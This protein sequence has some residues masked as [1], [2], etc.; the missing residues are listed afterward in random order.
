MIRIPVHVYKKFLRFALENANPLDDSQEWRECIGLIL[1]QIDIDQEEITVSDIVPIDTGSSV[2]VDITSYEKVFS[3][4]PISRIEQGEVI[5]GWAHTHP[6]LGLF[7]SGTDKRTQRLYQQMH[8]MSFG[9]VL[10]PM[11]VT[12]D[13]AGFKIFRVDDTGSRAFSV[14]YLLEEHIDFLNARDHIISDLYP[15]PVDLPIQHSITEVS[16]RM[17]KISIWGPEEINLN[18]LLE[19]KLTINLPE[20]QFVRAEYEIQTDRVVGEHVT[21]KFVYD[22]PFFHEIISSGV[23]SIHSFRPERIGKIQIR[24]KNLN[25][26]IYQQ[27]KQEMP[28]LCLTTQVRE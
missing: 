25:L 14:N 5:V 23:L 4:I 27:K 3:L 20:E 8:P 10:D 9:L 7:F 26:S 22:R 13:F 24:I 6:G 28:E 15:V 21:S 11:K 2:F 1:G 16:W 12:T 19:V 17:I 18:Q